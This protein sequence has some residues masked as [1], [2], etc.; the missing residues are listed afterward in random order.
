M[1]KPYDGIPHPAP[2]T[3]RGIGT[4]RALGRAAASSLRAPPL[5]FCIKE[6]KRRSLAPATVDE[7]RQPVKPECVERI[8]DLSRRRD[9]GS[10]HPLLRDWHLGHGERGDR[11]CPILHA[12]RTV[13][14]DSSRMHRANSAIKADR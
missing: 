12:L 1:D 6:Y 14:N 13:E 3:W 10:R 2:P 8:F 5:N 7:G 11:Q 4:G 9:R